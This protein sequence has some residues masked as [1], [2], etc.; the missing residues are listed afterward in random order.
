MFLFLIKDAKGNIPDTLNSKMKELIAKID[1]LK[2]KT[3]KVDHVIER[4]EKVEKI[5]KSG[6]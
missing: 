4:T 1:S 5:D 3:E 2:E 6:R